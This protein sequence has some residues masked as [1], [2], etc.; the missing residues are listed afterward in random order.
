MEYIERT[1]PIFV[2]DELVSGKV[3]LIETLIDLYM[4]RRKY[5]DAEHFMNKY[6]LRGVDVP[7]PLRIYQSPLKFHDAFGPT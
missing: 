1:Y 3:N 2:V 6:R 7:D 4:R 5:A